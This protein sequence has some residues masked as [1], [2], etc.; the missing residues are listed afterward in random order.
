MLAVHALGVGSC[1]VARARETFQSEYGRALMA[2]W[3]IPDDCEPKL[4]ITFGYPAGTYPQPKTRREG[5]DV[6]IP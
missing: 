1:L 2:E 6:R 5:R 3:G 4:H